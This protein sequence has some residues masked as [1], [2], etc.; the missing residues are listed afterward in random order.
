MLQE[1]NIRDIFEIEAFTKKYKE[2]FVV[3]FRKGKAEGKLE[4]MLAVA[5]TMLIDGDAVEKISKIT[6]LSITDIQ[7]LKS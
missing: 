3:G 7:K 2:N 5:N 6:G 4:E 1:K